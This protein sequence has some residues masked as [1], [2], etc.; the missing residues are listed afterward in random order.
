MPAIGRQVVTPFNPQNLML[1]NRISM[2]FA[3][4]DSKGAQSPFFELGDV[5]TIEI[6]LAETFVEKKSVRQGVQQTIKRLISDQAGEITFAISEVVGRNLQ[7]LFR[8][9]STKI[10]DGVANPEFDIIEQVRLRLT[11]TT[12]VA[13]APTLALE[14]GENGVLFNREIT[15]QSVSNLDSTVNYVDATDYTFVQAVEGVNATA[16]L[17]FGG[18]T[19]AGGDTLDFTETDAAGGVTTLTAGTEFEDGAT[20]GSVGALASAVADAI[21]AYTRTYTA[22]AV[23]AVVTVKSQEI[24]GTVPADIVATGAAIVLD[25]GGATHAFGGATATSPATIARV[26]DGAIVNGAEVVVVFTYPRKGVELQLQSGQILEGALR[27]QIL[28]TAGPQG[29]YEFPRVSLEI[30]GNITVN[31]EEFA[32]AGMKATILTAGDG[33]RGKY[34]QLCNFSDFFVEAAVATC[35]A[36]L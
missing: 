5:G 24:D 25:L 1:P 6:N 32:S 33:T 10:L 3:P 11:G 20:A 35:P 12:A 29:I 26:A 21:N 7:L 34:I 22:V 4:F 31:P 9:A 23:G 30:D 28:S 8:P 18:F 17:T 2:W 19:T 13:I 14:A 15:L 27:L 16:T 36:V